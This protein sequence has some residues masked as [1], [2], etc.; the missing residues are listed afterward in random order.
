LLERDRRQEPL[1]R[2][3]PA[4]RLRWPHLP[5][6]ERRIRKRNQG[7]R[8]IHG[9]SPAPPD[10]RARRRRGARPRHGLD[11]RAEWTVQI[12]LLQARLTREQGMQKK[13]DSMHVTT[14][15]SRAGLVLLG[16][17]VALALS[18]TARAQSATAKCDSGK[19]KC[20]TSLV[21]GLLGCYSKD[22]AK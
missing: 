15:R 3:I 4:R 21:T 22:N 2:G 1:H 6:Q 20:V 13:G 18:G 14:M 19:E 8:V 7:V 10:A 16:G 12:P 5:D 9:V 11:R 17:A